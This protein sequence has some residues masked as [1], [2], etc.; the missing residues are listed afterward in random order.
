M[1]PVV[2]EDGEDYEGEVED[3]P[4]LD[5]LSAAHGLAGL[6]APDPRPAAPALPGA[7]APGN[8]APENATPEDIARELGARVSLVPYDG[9][10]ASPV[11]VQ[12][13]GVANAL[14]RARTLAALLR[15]AGHEARVV[16]GPG[17]LPPCATPADRGTLDPTLRAGLEAR[18]RALAPRAWA[19]IAGEREWLERAEATPPA[20]RLAWVQ[21]RRDGAWV[22]LPLP[23]EAVDPAAQRATAPLDDAALG[24][25]AWT[26]T[27]RLTNVPQGAG[28]PRDV[29]VHTA[30]AEALHAA[31]V[32]VTNLPDRASARFVPTLRVAGR[33][34]QG[35]P[36]DGRTLARQLLSVEVRGQGTVRRATRVLVE[37]RAAGDLER[38]LEVVALAR[39]V[40]TTGPVSDEVHA[41]AVA[42]TLAHGAA[43]LRGED[44]GWLDAP[45]LRALALLG[46]SRALAGRVGDAAR[47]SLAFQ[48][49][50]AVAIEREWVAVDDG[51]IARRHGLDLV[52]PGHAFRGPA[53]DARGGRA[54]RPRRPPRARGPGRP[55]AGELRRRAGQGPRG[56]RRPRGRALDRRAMVGRGR[57]PRAAL[58]PARRRGPAPGPRAAGGSG[59][60]RRHGRR[61]RRHRDLGARRPARPRGRARRRGERARP[62]ARRAVLARSSSASSATSTSSRRATTARR[63]SSTASPRGSA[64]QRSD[65][66]T[67]RRRRS[68]PPCGRSSPTSS[69]GRSSSR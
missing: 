55:R 4:L 63:R 46:A 66:S 62:G 5:P 39:V 37:P 54:G 26:V 10:L 47:A 6:A 52:D 31:G 68:R 15:Q 30:R 40:V 49:R 11:Q 18:V 33:T 61:G 14:D 16:H 59:P 60:R 34:I 42:R 7:P 69:P 8:V 64:A 21:V 56:R 12:E 36:F 27:L 22:D 67:R 24:R 48:A 25:L 45:P 29:L 3:E 43:L 28:K 13:A 2:R 38:A 20:G 53:G 23:R 17:A 19:V 58:P 9:A 35:T 1:V 41:D 50:P 57:R 51:R 44:E 32:A 65:R